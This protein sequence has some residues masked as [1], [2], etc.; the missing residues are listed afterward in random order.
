[1][2]NLNETI[3]SIKGVG[4][5]TKVLLEKLGIFTKSDLLRYFPRTYDKYGEVTPIRD[6]KAETVGILNAAP[7]SHP[8][9]KVVGNK[10][11]VIAEVYD[12]SGKI[13]LS[14]FNMPYVRAKLS[15][16][17]HCIFRGKVVRKGKSLIM[18]QPEIL[19]M[20]EYRLKQQVLQPIYPLTKGITSNF[21]KKCLR[22]VLGEFE[23]KI[24]YLPMSLKKECGL[25]GLKAAIEEIHFPK[26]YSTLV[27][28]RKRLVFD[29]FFLFSLSLDKMKQEKS[30]EKSKF[31]F[32][33]HPVV[34]EFLS[35]LPFTMTEAQ[36]R[37]W[38]EVRGDVGSGTRMNRL[39]QGDVGSGK[40]LIAILACLLAV[41]NGYQASLMVPTEVLARQH[42]ES[43]SSA[44]NQFGVKTVLLTGAIK[45]KERKEVLSQISLGEAGVII[46][47]HA[48]IQDKVEYQDLALVITD[49]QHR[50]GVR[51]REKLMEKGR[52]PHVMVMSATPI[53]RTLAII[54]YG[55]LD[56]SLVD[57]L[58]AERLPIK[59]CVVD[60]G[61]RNT[62]FNFIKEEVEKG[63]QAYVICPMVEASEENTEL[64]DV[65]S[66]SEKLR[67]YYAGKVRVQY[68]H[69]KLKN[70][71]KNSIMES[72][73]KGE[74]DVL[75]ST[76]VVE[77]GVNVPNATVMMI[78]NADRFG[79][80]SL[81]Q[82]RGRIGRGSF[83]SYCIFMSKNT[84][85]EAMERLMILKNSNDGFQI[86]EEDLKLRGSG[87]IFGIRQSGEMLFALGDVLSDAAIL[88]SA[89]EVMKSLSD[90][91]KNECYDKGRIFYQKSFIY[92]NEI[93]TL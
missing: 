13:E 5:K 56:I 3:L 11:I 60:G 14:W 1:M 50:F 9:I 80:A 74:I 42:Y 71:E 4:A 24:D 18:V 40:T 54:L 45:G 53:P 39:I 46:G 6:L 32:S 75:V 92:G 33:F 90:K 27:E 26:S 47:T 65:V 44:L 86:A 19:T 10:K 43:F 25:M 23:A 2:S 28:A 52:E 61:Y 79:L 34:D 55:D 35:S 49:E 59:N 93:N 63:H 17:I 7:L 29:E 20:A 57:E 67:E 89:S 91:S 77:V 70:E 72:F 69:G 30:K 88:K 66:Y 81:H 21:L 37:T 85:E 51:Q 87:D 78:E 31:L 41:K 73:S 64:E 58:P 22:E 8:L 84:S 68:L 83:Q 15:K 48:L 16:G 76:T 36:K 82:L 62:S 38:L 12:G